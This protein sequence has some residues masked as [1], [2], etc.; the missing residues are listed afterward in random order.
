MRVSLRAN[1]IRWHK[2]NGGCSGIS[3][4]PHALK[5]LREAVELC[6]ATGASKAGIHE[7]MLSEV[8]KADEKNEW[9]YNAGAI[10][11][12]VA[13]INISLQIFCH[14][15][16]IIADDQAEV[17]YKILLERNWKADEFSIFRK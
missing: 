7:A 5:V 10:K 2:D 4:A 11:D 9:G 17:K 14:Y 6:V 16:N 3:L 8:H 13:D 12:E 15:A 1:L